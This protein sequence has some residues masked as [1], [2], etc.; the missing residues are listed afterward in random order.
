MVYNTKGLS[1]PYLAQNR[2]GAW[3]T[4]KCKIFLGST[5]I[6]ILKSILVAETLNRRVYDISAGTLSMT[7]IFSKL[8][9]SSSDVS[10]EPND[11]TIINKANDWDDDPYDIF[12]E[13]FEDLLNSNVFT[14]QGYIIHKYVM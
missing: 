4:E 12:D 10:Y 1:D 11:K 5:V 9:L 14:I 7:S 13:P 3:D 8:V 2:K 6:D